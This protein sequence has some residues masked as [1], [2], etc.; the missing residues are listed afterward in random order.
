MATNFKEKE[1]ADILKADA[2]ER[3]AAE[4]RYF[5]D[6]LSALHHN[7]FIVQHI[8]DFPVDLFTM[9]GSDYFLQ[10]VADN[11]LQMAVLQVTK[12]TTD[13]GGDA[14]TLRHF[15]NFMSSAVKDEYQ[16]DYRE[17]LKKAKFKPRVESLIQKA[18]RL[19]DTQIAHSVA[20]VPGDPID[21]LAFSE[22]KEIVTELTNLFEVASFSIE[23]RYLIIAYDPTVRH[24][25]GA[26]P[27]PDIERI[28]DGIARE[29][30]VLHLPETNPMAWPF[31]RQSWPPGRLEVF[32]RYRRKFGLPEA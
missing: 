16:A 9:P 6:K 15:K 17:V 13:S 20:P 7:I 11:F 10:L 12:L 31:S 27:R 23:Y 2:L 32:N 4:T 22:I 25:A 8:A 28:L 5:H 29:S 21:V 3:H 24:P 26:D 19:R 1:P 30:S 18:K 14:H